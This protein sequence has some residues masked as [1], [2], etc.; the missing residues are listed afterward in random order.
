MY[1]RSARPVIYA[2]V[3][4]ASRLACWIPLV[5]QLGIPQATWVAGLCKHYWG[6]EVLHPD[7][8]RT[9]WGQY[10]DYLTPQS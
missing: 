3:M 7:G 1:K 4:E 10:P 6:A 9:M 8:L 5:A 2:K